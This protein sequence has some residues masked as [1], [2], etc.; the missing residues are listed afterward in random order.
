MTINQIREKAE[1]GAYKGAMSID[2]IR[3]KYSQPPVRAQNELVN[4]AQTAQ[5]NS[6]NVYGGMNIL[7]AQSNNVNAPAAVTANA[8]A[9]LKKNGLTDYYNKWLDSEYLNNADIIDEYLAARNKRENNATSWLGVPVNTPNNG[10]GLGVKEEAAAA[11]KVKK[12]L[13]IGDEQLNDIYNR[14]KLSGT[15]AANY[16]SGRFL[17]G[18]YSNVQNALQ[19]A[20]A[21]VSNDILAPAASVADASIRALGGNT[22]LEGF[23]KDRAQKSLASDFMGANKFADYVNDLVRNKYMNESQNTIGNLAENAGAMLPAIATGNIAGMLGATAAGAEAANFAVFGSGAAGNAT[24]RAMQEGADI[25]T[26]LSYG[27]MSGMVEVITEKMFAGIA[28]MNKS[29]VIDD[30]VKGLERNG[31]MRM[32]VDTLGEGVEEIVAEVIDPFLKRATYDQNATNADL[33]DLLEAAKSGVLLSLIMNGAGIAMRGGDISALMGSTEGMT[34]AE[35]LRNDKYGRLGKTDTGMVDD[36]LN[37]YNQ[38]IDNIL[39]TDRN[40]AIKGLIRSGL[41]GQEGGEAYNLAWDM[42]QRYAEG[43]DL[44]GGELRQLYKANDN[45]IRQENDAEVERLAKGLAPSLSAA[46]IDNYDN[47]T[48]PARYYLEMKNAYNAAQKGEAYKGDFLNA[49]QISA[50]MQAAQGTQNNIASAKNT[51]YN[52]L[53]D[54]YIRQ[55]IE[56]GEI[57][58]VGKQSSSTNAGWENNLASVEQSGGVEARAGEAKGRR[59][60][61]F[62]AQRAAKIAA[63]AEVQRAGQ[64]SGQ[65]IH[66]RGATSEKSFKVIPRSVWSQDESLD[67]IAQNYKKRGMNVVFIYGNIGLEGGGYARGAHR[68]NVMYI[69]IADGEASAEQIAAH[70]YFHDFLDRYAQTGS[71]AFKKS[72][73]EARSWAVQQLVKKIRSDYGDGID[74]LMTVYAETYFTDENGN[75]T[76]DADY[77]LEEI[78]CDAAADI[79][80]LAGRKAETQRAPLYGETVREELNRMDEA[81]TRADTDDGGEKYSRG[82]YWYP[83]LTQEERSLLEETIE[84]ELP[85]EDKYIDE[86]TKWAFVQTAENSVFALYGVG[87]G[88]EA[89]ILYA[90]GGSEAKTD[91]AQTIMTMEGINEA[92][93]N[94]ASINK[95]FEAIRNES[96]EHSIDMPLAQNRSANDDDVRIS[97][98]ERKRD[99]RTNNSKSKADSGEEHYSRVTPKQSTIARL[100]KENEN[101]R[102]RAEY[103]QKQTKLTKPKILNHKGVG[104]IASDLLTEYDS[105]S[106]HK[107][108]HA[109]LFKLGNEILRGRE[110]GHALTWERVTERAEALARDI[111]NNSRVLVNTD[112]Y[113]EYNELKKYLRNNKIRYQNDGN[114]PDFSAWRKKHKGLN[115]RQNEGTPA[116]IAYNELR[117]RFGNALFPE[118][119]INPADQVIRMGEVLN[120]FEPVFE[121][122]YSYDMALA[123]EETADD[124]I[125]R[126]LNAA[127]DKSFADKQEERYQA[128]KADSAAK[129]SEAK[130]K[131]EAKQAE[132]IKALKADNAARLREVRK[133]RD[134]KIKT[135]KEYYAAAKRDRAEAKADS[136]AR[137]RLLRI[138]KR[139]KNRKLPAATRAMLD[140]YIAD[141]DTVA[142][143]ITGKSIEKLSELRDWYTEQIEN[144]PNFVRDEGIEKALQRLSNRK[145]GDMSAEEVA[146]LT[147]I[148]LGIEHEIREHNK[149]I[150][151]EYKKNI[152]EAGAQTVMDLQDVKGASLAKLNK[153]ETEM[154]SPIRAIHRFVGYK[155]DS[156]LMIFANE[157]NEG[158]H[159]MLDYQRKAYEAFNQFLEDKDFMKSLTGK[160]ATKIK[161]QGITPTGEAGE[162]YISPAMRIALAAHAMNPQNMKHIVD[163]G[164]TIPDFDLYNKGKQAEAYSRNTRLRFTKSQLEG[165]AATLTPKERAFLNA[166]MTYFNTTSR[167]A[168]N[169]TSEALKGYSLA[170]VENYF[171]INS[172]DAFLKNDFES[173]KFDGT[174]EG[175]GFLKDRIRGA[176]NPIYLRD[177]VTVLNKAIVQHSRYYGLAVPLRNFNKLWNVNT[178]GATQDLQFD[179]ENR[180]YTEDGDV[181]NGYISS[182][183]DAM[184]RAWFDAGENY[185]EKL[186]KDLSGVR[187]QAETFEKLLNK[188]RGS[189]AKAVLSINFGVAVKQAASYPTAAAVLGWRPLVRAMADIG[190]V[191]MDT[192][193]KYTPVQYYRSRGYSTQELG[194]L[195]ARGKSLPKALNWIQGMDVVTTR[196]LWKASEYYVRRANRDLTVGS[197]AYYSE[198]AA[199]YN[200]VIEETQPNYTTMQ[201]P[202]LLRS[203]SALLQSLMMFKTQPFQNYN[204][205]SD[206]LGN[207]AAKRRAWKAMGTPEAKAVYKEAKRTAVR[208]VTSQFVANAVF[209]GMAAAWALFR[210]KTK[211]YKDDDDEYTWKSVM[212]KIGRDMVGTAAGMVPFGSEFWELVQS[213]AFNDTYYGIDTVTASA[214]SDAGS[215]IKKAWNSTATIIDDANNPDKEANWN[216]YIF[217]MESVVNAISK[218]VGAPVENVTKLLRA[219]TLRT[220]NVICD[221]EYEAQYVALRISTDPVTDSGAYI[222]NLYKAKINSAK[223]YT[224][225]YNLMVNAGISEDKIKTGMEKRMKAAEGV[226]KVGD[227][228]ERYL[229]PKQET[230]YQKALRE[231]EQSD[232]Y[233]A[234]TDEQ[235]KGA[236][237]DLYDLYAQTAD[238]KKM[239]EKIDEGKNYDVSDTDYIEFLLS[240]HEHDEPTENG[241][242][243]SY[244]TEEIIAALKAMDVSNKEKAYLYSTKNSSKANNPWARYLPR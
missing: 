71:K 182:V 8:G 51:G 47:T 78:L 146:D 174:I 193:N 207:L 205:L 127:E 120:G 83:D 67:K 99:R 21:F 58:N 211:D 95:L 184:R 198:V 62:E 63:N 222:D 218:L 53:N 219:V 121:N 128:L 148:L 221:D 229:A 24:Q 76:V 141:I 213:L 190:R 208:A 123:V 186:V 125:D 242:Y 155:D 5:Q 199:I 89:T 68:G 194:D 179:E 132:A 152:Y 75:I 223:S 107:E 188:V 52:L 235:K 178:R 96:R 143:S 210:G 227:L 100:E 7:D 39:N 104:K 228:D 18:A 243:G 244:T 234:A 28:G 77:I 157:L 32:L 23:F 13:G 226:E 3:A 201:R 217:Q 113:R 168:I 31:T 196:K 206:S 230:I 40:E 34:D 119:I 88:T 158:Q 103:W 41:S 232:T 80:I 84:R 138:V 137:S 90:S 93:T 54:D 108:L 183:K 74:E 216:K 124:I 117:E 151:S 139:L 170:D 36:T 159:K 203:E 56:K 1:S 136:E 118:D 94:R 189:Y 162:A 163:G 50:A 37:N 22:D 134:D 154:L 238:G 109:A 60:G 169:E 2:E 91:Y 191:S 185:I 26:A 111:L 177:V 126:L 122:P 19:Y 130:A 25:G 27:V 87:D 72:A 144:N 14:T 133:Q 164:V 105:V 10:K 197:P 59:P 57:P 46:L 17:S 160:H 81:V 220:A 165:I 30:L 129:L 153:L 167:N 209:V 110:E 114:I 237:S 70:E 161:V 147:N 241:N 16:Y 215:A 149:F 176:A 97:F 35:T 115:L 116:D 187:K 140:G 212:S 181:I 240:L 202:G 33:K 106:D 166:V 64:V 236:K 98:A 49:N 12:A 15:A 6:S 101:L 192:I 69:N 135:L 11:E 180:P 44:T 38:R 214:L 42:R 142:K 20:D 82:K 43:E 66:L 4:P 173:L 55:M 200:R 231:L 233:K 225:L 65:E 48:S 175:M 150:E 92:E 224:E 86:Y 79:D 112:E 29:G 172:D 156:P 145:I 204:I 171:P 61:S 73:D 102:E 9:S 131:A 45:E 195:T 239:R 85:Q